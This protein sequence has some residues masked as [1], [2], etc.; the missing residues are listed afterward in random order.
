M[1]KTAPDDSSFHQELLEVA[2][3]EFPVESFLL[4][5]RAG[6]ST[7]DCLDALGY[8]ITDLSFQQRAVLAVD[9]SDEPQIKALLGYSV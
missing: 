9:P 8:H 1:D 3:E 7:E 2:R 4:M 6:L 5:R